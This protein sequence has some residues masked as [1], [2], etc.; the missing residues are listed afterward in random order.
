MSWH[1]CESNDPKERDLLWKQ[2]AKEF[3]MEL[4]N[5]SHTF[6]RGNFCIATKACGWSSQRDRNV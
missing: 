5:Q 2:L 6:E 1:N 3:E 4:R